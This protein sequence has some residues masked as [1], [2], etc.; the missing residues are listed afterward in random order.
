MLQVITNTVSVDYLSKPVEVFKEMHRVLK[1][2]G[3]AIMSFSNRCFPT[4]GQH[5]HCRPHCMRLISHGA[6]TA[7]TQR[8]HCSERCHGLAGRADSG[9]SCKR[10]ISYGTR[11]GSCAMCLLGTTASTEPVCIP[12]C[13]VLTLGCL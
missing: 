10:H 3:K 2:G 6:T 11:S 4:K 9:R 1:P 8:A 7:P 5:H 12:K 13:V